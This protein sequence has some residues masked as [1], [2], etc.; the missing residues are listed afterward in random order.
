MIL[1]IPAPDAFKYDFRFLL[2]LHDAAHFHSFENEEE[3]MS[4]TKVKNLKITIANLTKRNDYK[5]MSESSP[6]SFIVNLEA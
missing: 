3:C 4:L 6:R 5:I 2:S 1:Q